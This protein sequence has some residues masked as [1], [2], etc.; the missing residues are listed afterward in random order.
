MFSKVIIF[1]VLSCQIYSTFSD[2]AKCQPNESSLCVTD[3]PY[4][5][6]SYEPELR[7]ISSLNPNIC[8]RLCNKPNFFWNDCGSRCPITC[9]YR[10][11]RI[12]ILLCQPGC[13]CK[14]GFILNEDTM[15]CVKEEECPIYV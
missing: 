1:I 10:E 12:C 3:S 6:W 13:F 14:S 2:S 4:T 7:I 5:R 11:P 9:K 15:E 8:P